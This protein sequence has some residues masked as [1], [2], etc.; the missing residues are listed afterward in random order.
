VDVVQRDI[1]HVG[2]VAGWFDW[3]TDGNVASD[4]CS[5]REGKVQLAR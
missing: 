3:D 2:G 5:K 1:P 4:F